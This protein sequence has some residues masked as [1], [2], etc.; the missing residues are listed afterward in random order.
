MTGEELKRWRNRKGLTQREAADLLGMG[1]TQYGAYERD[2]VMIPR[3]V[4][5]ACMWHML[6]FQD[7]Q[8]VFNEFYSIK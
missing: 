8:M 6:E 7:R 4:P 2:Q 5:A 1:T 3:I